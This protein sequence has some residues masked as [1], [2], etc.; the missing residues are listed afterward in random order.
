M[1]SSPLIVET[2]AYAISLIPEIAR[3]RDSACPESEP[4]PYGRFRLFGKRTQCAVSQIS[5]SV[6]GT[7]FNFPVKG[8]VGGGDMA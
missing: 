5:E 2:W 7:R 3:V 4:L 8:D 6:G 1:W